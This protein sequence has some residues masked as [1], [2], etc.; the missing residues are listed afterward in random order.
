VTNAAN[1]TTAGRTVRYT[2]LLG[3]GVLAGIA[4]TVLVVELAFRRLTG[5]EYVRVRQAEFAPLTWSIGAV[6]VVTLAAVTAL[7]VRARRAP[8]RAPRLAAAALVLLLL[9]LAVSLAVNGPV[10]I[11]QSGWHAATPPADWAH[12]RDR[13]LVA[14]AV[15]TAAILAALGCVSAA[16]LEE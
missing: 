6:T 14:H 12:L 13:W 2:S 15:R 8:G 11:A 5:P 7:A 10:N 16:V 4:V 9:A 1:T 3:C